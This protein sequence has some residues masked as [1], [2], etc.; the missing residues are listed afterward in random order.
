MP[1]RNIK[2]MLRDTH[3]PVP[4]ADMRRRL[5]LIVPGLG[6]DRGLPLFSDVTCITPITGRCFARS[7]ATT[8]NGAIL[9]HATRNNVANYREVVKSG[10][11]SLLCLG[12]EVFGRWADVAVRLCRLW[13]PRRPAAY[14]PWFAEAPHKPWQLGGGGFRLSPLSGSWRERC[15]ATPAQTSS[16]PSWR[17]RRASPTCPSERSEWL[18]GP[19]VP[20]AAGCFTGAG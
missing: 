20:L 11:G 4:P 16:R 1:D 13:L 5:D 9:R 6:V 18:D 8:I 15:C 19:R 14:H 10:S 12:C 2:R 7:G 3:V 17:T